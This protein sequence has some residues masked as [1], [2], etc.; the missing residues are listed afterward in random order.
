MCVIR[1]G[2]RMLLNCIYNLLLWS[3]LTKDSGFDHVYMCGHELYCFQFTV[4]LNKGSVVALPTHLTQNGQ[5]MDHKM[6]ISF[7]LY[8]LPLFIGC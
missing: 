2:P 4:Q 7:I 5:V 1:V 8:I 6:V 3:V